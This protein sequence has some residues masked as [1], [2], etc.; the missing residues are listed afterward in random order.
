MAV[1]I[2]LAL[3]LI[4]QSLC[5]SLTIKIKICLLSRYIVTNKIVVT[6]DT[7]VLQIHLDNR[8]FKNDVTEVSLKVKL[9]SQLD[10]YMIN[11]IYL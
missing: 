4:K 5:S 11:R 9:C 10:F 2:K 6:S 8:H 7:K 1:Q 3:M